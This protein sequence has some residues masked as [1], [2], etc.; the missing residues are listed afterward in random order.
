MITQARLKELLHYDQETGIFTRL[1]TVSG[2]YKAGERAGTISGAQKM[3]FK[4][5]QIWIDQKGYK[6]HRLAWLWMTGKF[7]EHMIDHINSDGLDNRWVN[8]RE[9]TH[10]Q[11]QM[12]RKCFRSLGIKGVYCRKGNTAKKWFVVITKQDKRHM[13]G[14]F[15]TFDEAKAVYLAAVAELHGEFARA[16]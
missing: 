14:H 5:R 1:V 13:L 4:Y 10:S 7:P 9:A 15:Y 12:N 6:E 3:K 8:L 16:A 2:G 11:N